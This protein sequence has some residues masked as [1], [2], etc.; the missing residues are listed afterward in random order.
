MKN[1]KQFLAMKRPN[2]LKPVS[3][4]LLVSALLVFIS[5]MDLRASCF[6][7]GDTAQWRQLF[8]GKDLSGWKH[9][10]QDSMSVEDG[11]I[12][13]H[14]GMGLLYWEG[15]KFGNCKIRV[16]WKMEKTNS[17]AGVFVRVPIEPYEE[18]MPVFYGHEIQ[19]VKREYREGWGKL[20]L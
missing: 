7:E 6:Q 12:R 8:N 5:S 20:E 1:P 4:L 19:F 15:E 16:V 14:G 10:G 3:F 17:N 18:W 11:M 13:G 2:T 9:A